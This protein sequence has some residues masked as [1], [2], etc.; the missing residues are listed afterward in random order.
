MLTGQFVTLLKTSTVLGQYF[1][2]QHILNGYSGLGA[3]NFVI[4]F[5]SSQVRF[6]V[7]SSIYFC[8]PKS[9]EIKQVSDLQEMNCFGD[10]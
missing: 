3:I 4:F 10:W 9:K 1:M 8:Y 6:P 5:L 2:M 7:T